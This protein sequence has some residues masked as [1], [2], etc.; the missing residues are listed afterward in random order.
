MITRTILAA[1]AIFGGL[2]R[3][4]ALLN[5]GHV[6]PSNTPS[7]SADRHRPIL[8]T[9]KQD[10]GQVKPHARSGVVGSPPGA[11][12]ADPG[13][14]HA[15][16]Y[17]TAPVSC[18]AGPQCTSW[19]AETAR[20]AGTEGAG[21]KPSG[22]PTQGRGDEFLSLPENEGLSQ[23]TPAWGLHA[24]RA[25]CFLPCGCLVLEAGVGRDP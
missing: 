23:F 3:V 7:S 11:G 12:L 19:M 24:P 22:A 13:V 14:T 5:T 4:G 8:Q 25:P 20:P 9:R 21:P 16:T 6:F 1:A 18:S 10:L 15:Q 17:R 2:I